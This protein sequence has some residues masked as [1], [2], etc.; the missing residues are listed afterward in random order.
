MLF[1]PP[2]SAKTTYVSRLL[3]PWVL[4]RKPTW[5][6]IA[7]SHTMPLALENSQYARGYIQ[8]F[9]NILGVT[10]RSTQ[11]QR[12]HTDAGGNYLAAGVDAGISGFRADLSI[13]DDPVRSRAD[14]DSET[15]RENV[16]RWFH[17]DLARRSKPDCKIVLMHT[18]WHEDDLAGRLLA[19]QPERWRV[20]S[21]PALAE[22]ND[23]LGREPGD[24][25]WG[26][27]AGYG[28][29][30]KLLD[31]RA[32]LEQSGMSREW[33][34]LYQQ[35]PRPADGSIFKPDKID[36]ID[37][38]PLGMT[39]ARGWDLAAT[40]DLGTSKAAY[41]AGVRI[42]RAPNG[43]YI[44]AD[45]RRARLDPEGVE[46]LILQ[47][48]KVDGAVRIGLPQD[49]GQ[50]GK[51]QVAYLTNRLA[52]HT[53]ESTPESGDK[54]T[55]AGPYASQVNVGN[56]SLLRGEWNAAYL[57]ELRSFPSGSTADQVDASSRAFSMVYEGGA[58]LWTKL[59]RM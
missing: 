52:G 45:V 5:N 57:E 16:W 59:G 29:G 14:A 41:T 35:N 19:T 9:E 10:L 20:V 38:L 4:Q 27:D 36:I 51:F 7:A 42:G 23:P 25:L 40:K 21:L 22:E 58:A 50:A 43:R 39:W 2:G 3:P 54:A 17:G 26:D 46:N 48:A 44:V 6:I 24:P 15:Y 37:A 32:E 33:G 12:W 8:S 47:T 30:N 34:S 31:I 55:R 53:V 1:A 49:P 18:R 13:I 11:M 56:V 28:Y